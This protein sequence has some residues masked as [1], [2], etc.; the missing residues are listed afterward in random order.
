MS[1]ICVLRRFPTF[2]FVISTR[3]SRAD[4][5]TRLE[6]AFEEPS[7]SSWPFPKAQ[8]YGSIDGS[9]FR[10]SPRTSALGGNAVANVS[11]EIIP[12]PDG[13]V[14]INVR[15]IDW[16]IYVFGAPFF[17]LLI[18]FAVTGETV[19]DKWKAAGGVLWLAI[20]LS[21][22]YLADAQ[23]VRS[24]FERIFEE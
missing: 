1:N 4:A 24:I 8:F 23:F 13:G 2:D 19:A 9:A 17:A 5:I 22:V 21:V 7:K 18:F 15:I 14:D 20:I 10:C 3:L 16:F 6:I 12:R 11:G